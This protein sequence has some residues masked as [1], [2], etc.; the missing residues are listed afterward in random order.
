MQYKVLTPDK[1]E[2]WIECIG[3]KISYKDAPAMLLSFRDTTERKKEELAVQE[4]EKK[5]RTIFENS[6]Y[7]ISINSIPDGKFVAVNAAFL[8]NSGYTGS[9][10]LGKNPVDLGLLSLLDF[11]KLTSHLLLS[12]KIENVPMTM[13]GKGGIRVQVLFSTIPIK[14]NDRP[15]ILTMAVNVTKLKVIEEELHKSNEQLKT[16]FKELAAT[17]AK[18]RQNYD[19]ISKKEKELRSS[20]E[21]YRALYNN[22]PIMLFTLDPKGKVI[23][24]NH[25]GASQLGYSDGELEGQPVLNVFYSDDRRAVT[26]QL[27]ICLKS[28]GEGVHWQFRKVRKDGRMIWVDEHARAI[29][30]SEGELSVLVV[31]QDITDRKTIDDELRL[32][33]VSVDRAADEV[34]WLDFEGNILYVNDSACRITG[35]SQ[36]EFLA[37]KIFKLDPDFTRGIWDKSIA[38]LR[39]RK[40]QLFTTRHQRKDGVLIDVEI[41]SVYVSKDD[42]EYSFAFVR[43]ISWRKETDRALIESDKRSRLFLQSAN[44]AILIHEISEKGQGRFIEVND[45][46][47]QMLGYSRE[48]LL[49]MSIPDIDVPEQNS[50]IPEI[51]K[52]L[53]STGKVVFQT[54]FMTKDGRRIPIED[55]N[56]LINLD[57]RRAVLCIARDLSEQKRTEQVLQA[58]NHKLNLLNSITRHDILNSIAVLSGYLNLAKEMKL[59]PTMAQYIEKMDTVTNSISQH[60]EFT[61]V[62]QDLGTTAPQWQ[63]L[64]AVLPR[65][66]VP[67][68]VTFYTDL[69]GVKVYADP[70]LKTVFSN[71]LDNTLRHGEHTKTIKVSTYETTNGLVIVWEDDG[72]GIPLKEKE[73]IFRKGYGKNT[74]LGLFLT[75]EILSITGITI[76]ETGEPGKGARFEM[77]VP[78]GA[79]RF[80]G[81]GQE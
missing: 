41:M 64:I 4:N 31:C 66:R 61:R 44:D 53:L 72:I 57:G 34:F 55:S 43:D 48:E 12:G 3:K 40:T 23:S 71:L 46:A 1:K 52:K 27:Q 65:S 47:C 16:A 33:K 7:P 73:K 11:G 21:R 49:N 28:P 37:M 22:N 60:I 77:T 58:A 70:I 5:F 32:L 69:P 45:Q 54:W 29:V 39:E 20:E 63:D 14:I 78:K 38:D 75:K 35:Y 9:E 79:Y 19:D 26:E 18:L 51:L 68:N 25:S 59:D 36:E 15:A 8:D 56:R 81:A 74:G 30:S 10:V 2:K 67:K 17:E 76:S 6:L 80:A 13:T 50:H 24:V 42:K 62:Y